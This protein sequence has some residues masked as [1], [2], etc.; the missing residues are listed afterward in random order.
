MVGNAMICGHCKKEIPSDDEREF[1]WYCQGDLCYGCWE[2][3]GDCG[4]E[5][6]EEFYFETERRKKA[7]LPLMRIPHA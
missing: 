6:V 2:K 7:S 5:E 3:F 1:C 4:H